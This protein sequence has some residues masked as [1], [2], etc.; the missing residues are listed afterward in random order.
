MNATARLSRMPDWHLLV[1]GSVVFVLLLGALL[2]PWG[3]VS[4]HGVA[5]LT[6]LHHGVDGGAGHGHDD[7]ANVTTASVGQ[8]HHAMDHSHDTMHASPHPLPMTA[9]EAPVWLGQRLS[10]LPSPPVHR[11][12]RPPSG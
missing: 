9:V 12:E 6:V 5:D 11:L 1:H 8:T 10:R 4:S 7:D 3:L 2:T